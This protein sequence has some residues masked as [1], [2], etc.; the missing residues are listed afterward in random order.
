MRQLLITLKRSTSGAKKNQLD[1]LQ[2]LGLRK[3]GDQ[4]L[5]QNNAAILGMIAKVRHMVTVEEVEVEE[6]AE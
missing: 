6:V 2:A 5:Q 3:L 1:N 4:V